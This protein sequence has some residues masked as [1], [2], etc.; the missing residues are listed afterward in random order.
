MKSATVEAGRNGR[1]G[2]SG[3]VKAEGEEPL[4][5][6][7]VRHHGLFVRGTR[8][9]R[10]FRERSSERAGIGMDGS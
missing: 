8:E 1:T 2:Y 7:H 5:S 4:L 3:T 9:K 6:P 10:D